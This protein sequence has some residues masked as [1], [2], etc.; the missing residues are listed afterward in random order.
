M[1][2]FY[3]LT[4]PLFVIFAISELTVLRRVTRQRDHARKA[5]Q[6]WRHVSYMR[7]ENIKTLK[8]EA[9]AFREELKAMRHFRGQVERADSIADVKVLARKILSDNV[10][11]F[12]F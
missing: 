8:A 7:D 5:A 4:A 6:S 9:K 3:W 12:D 1:I 2:W 11:S 10:A